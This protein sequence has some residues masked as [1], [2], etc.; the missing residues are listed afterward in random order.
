MNFEEF[1]RALDARCFLAGKPLREI[2]P[3]DLE[4]DPPIVA[5]RKYNGNFAAALVSRPGVVDFY[6]A[7]NLRLARLDRS[8]FDGGPWQHALEQA[9]PGTVFLGELF[10]ARAG[11]ESLGEFQKWYAWQCQGGERPAPAR[12][13]AFDLL[14]VGGR[15]L[16]DQ[17]Y[18][19]RLRHVPPELR[20]AAAPYKSLREASTAL[21][22]TS[23]GECEGF[24]FWDAGA[25]SV[26]KTGGQHQPR[27]GAWKVKPVVQEIFLLRRLKSAQPENLV[28]ILGKA[29]RTDFACG[30]GLSHS[31]RRELAAM[32]LS[33]K[34]ISVDIQHYGIDEN[35]KPEMPRAT[36]WSVAQDRLE[37]LVETGNSKEKG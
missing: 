11:I 22:V 8:G 37:L 17:P 26:C 36:G 34:K 13:L 19:E 3:V 7:S 20:V 10:I 25:A 35:G 18:E 27:G 5:S 16:Q 6:T 1:T 12:F 30:S 28:M 31:E 21:E 2:R 29:G 14:V 23:R 33:G 32:H 4:R 15:A 24:V 9:A